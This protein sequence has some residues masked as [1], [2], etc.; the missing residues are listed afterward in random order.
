VRPDRLAEAIGNW[1]ESI[2]T[3]IPYEVI[4][5]VLGANG[6]FRS[7]SVRAA[8]LRDADGKIVQ[9]FGTATDVTP[10]QTAQD[11]LKAADRRKDEFLAMLA[12]E[13]RNPLAPI[14]TAAVILKRGAHD[15]E[16]VAQASEIITRQVAHMASIVDDLLDVSRVTR[17][18]VTVRNDLVELNGA[19]TEAIEQTHTFIKQKNLRF[20]TQLSSSE[21]FVRGDRTRLVQVFSNILHNAAKYTPAG[22]VVELFLREK[23]DSVE[24]SVT[25][26]GV[27]IDPEFLPHIFDL[28]TQGERTP[29]RAQGG[30][31]LG[32]ALVKSLVKLHHGE[33]IARSEGLGKGSEFV[34][35]LPFLR[36]QQGES[37]SQSPLAQ[38]GKPAKDGLA[39]L[40]VDDNEDAAETLAMLLESAGHQVSVAFNGTK[41]LEFAADLVPD[42]LI[43]DIGL[44][45]IDGYELARRLR[46]MPEF[47]KSILVALTGYGQAEDKAKTRKAGFDHHLVKPVA[48]DELFKLIAEIDQRRT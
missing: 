40:V 21:L 39:I 12:H 24:F 7:F 22:G 8:P 2:A 36:G 25:D 11:E 44:P 28:F 16:R 34:V 4:L 43:L 32:L 10:I 38:S 9:W 3:G 18:L 1:K 42:L 20:S 19:V 30:L 45:D 47:Q 17:G 5:P 27:G 23:C 33:V 13:L 6:N 29:D 35:L 46:L 15:A 48:F 31:G 37:K 41:A 14:S 26:E